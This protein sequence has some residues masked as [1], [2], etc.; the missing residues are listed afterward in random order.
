MIT[1]CLPNGISAI[2]P[3]SIHWRNAF[4]ECLLTSRHVSLFVLKKEYSRLRRKAHRSMKPDCRGRFFPAGCGRD[5]IK[6]GKDALNGSWLKLIACSKCPDVR[7]P[8]GIWN[9]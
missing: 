6:D 8:Y 9:G 4:K 7:R 1:I 2:T 3:L 5:L